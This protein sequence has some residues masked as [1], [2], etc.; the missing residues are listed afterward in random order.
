MVLIE[1]VGFGGRERQLWLYWWDER[2]GSEWSGWWLTTDFIGN[3]EF[4]LTTGDAVA[5]PA[6]VPLGGWRSPMVE[7]QQLKRRL[8]LGFAVIEGSD[9]TLRTVGADA[10]T[11]FIP[12]GVCRI[13]LGSYEWRPDGM[14]HTKPAYQAQEKRA[15]PP[16]EPAAPEKAVAPQSPPPQP[17]IHPAIY[18]VIGVAAGIA[19]TLAI[20]GLRGRR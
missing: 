12:D 19:C 20:G 14:N 2:D 3:G 17:P 18:V 10:E 15:A 5:T 4:I 1:H 9:G 7:E 16:S 8:E 6:D 11:P 13:K